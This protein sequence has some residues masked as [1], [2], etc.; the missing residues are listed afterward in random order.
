MPFRPGR[1]GK[2]SY[3]ETYDG[4]LTNTTRHRWHANIGT[5][6]H[7]RGP[8]SHIVVLRLFFAIEPGRGERKV[9]SKI[10]TVL[11]TIQQERAIGIVRN[12]LVN[13]VTVTRGRMD[14]PSRSNRRMTNVSPDFRAFRQRPKPGRSCLTPDSL[15]VKIESLPTL[16]W[17]RASICRLRFWSSVLTRAYPTHRPLSG[18]GFTVVLFAADQWCGSIP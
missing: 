1:F 9:G 11:S 3:M 10:T 17:A 14:R 18:D 13:D 16:C 8:T 12:G 4:V 2:P 5:G 7:H 15:S 6:H